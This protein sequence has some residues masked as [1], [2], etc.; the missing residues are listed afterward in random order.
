MNRYW[1]K[2]KKYGYGI[3]PASWEG[4]ITTLILLGVILGLIFLQ[5][6]SFETE[7]VF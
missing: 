7:D 5:R 1:F 6:E 4:A 2:Q 3:K